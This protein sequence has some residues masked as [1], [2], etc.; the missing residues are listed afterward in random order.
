MSREILLEVLDSFSHKSALVAGKE[1]LAHG[2]PSKRHSQ[3]WA[4]GAAQKQNSPLRDP[5]LHRR[6]SLSALSKKNWRLIRTK[7]SMQ[8]FTLALFTAATTWKQRKCPSSDK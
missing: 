6:L 7:T 3:R 8:K 2:F 1:G 4:W 5:S